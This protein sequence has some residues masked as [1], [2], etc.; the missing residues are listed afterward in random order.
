[1]Y[2]ILKDAFLL[3]IVFLAG[4]CDFLK[5]RVPNSLVFPGIILALSLRI[6]EGGIGGFFS[7]LRDGIILSFPFYLLFKISAMGGGDVKLAFFLGNWAGM[8]EGFHIIFFALLFGAVAGIVEMVFRGELFSRIK[9][10]YFKFRGRE[11]RKF[12]PVY[13]P[14]GGAMAVASLYVFLINLLRR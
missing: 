10:L 4:A 11:V 12:N 1:M 5:G 9:N 6:V 13:V 7:G 2:E 8:E 3:S 14:F